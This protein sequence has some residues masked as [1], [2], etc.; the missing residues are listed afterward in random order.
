MRNTISI[1]RAKTTSPPNYLELTREEICSIIII[2]L[3]MNWD[4][5]EIGRLKF[6]ILN[7]FTYF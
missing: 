2:E 4:F 5:T 7:I 1:D 6:D 3:N